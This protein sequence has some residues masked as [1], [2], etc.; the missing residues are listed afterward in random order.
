MK[1][2]ILPIICLATAVFATAA[3][4][5]VRLSEEWHLWKSEHGKSYEDEVEELERHSIWLSNKEYIEQHNTRSDVFGYT[6][7][8]NKFGDLSNKEF[9]ESSQCVQDVKPQNIT[10]L[11]AKYGN[12]FKEFTV[13]LQN[14]PDTMDW[15]TSGAVGKVKDQLRCGCSYAFA[16]MGALEGASALSRGSLNLLSEQNI[17]DCSGIYGNNGCVC[18]DINKSFL[19]VIDNEGVDLYSSYRYQSKQYACRY[20][21]DYRGATARG[22][23]T[24]Q[25]GD[26][27]RLQ[28]ALAS[29]GPVS[30]YIDATSTSFQF[31]SSGILSVPS[32]S[33]TALS[34]AM[35]MTGY[36]TNQ[37]Q[38]YWLL[39][40]SWGPNWGELGYLRIVRN[41][42]NQCGVATAASYPTL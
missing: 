25:S 42:A 17:V 4:S 26:E 16:A 39:K 1:V 27:R 29:V 40:N 3:A 41:M 23:V 30:T 28:I 18:G 22:V 7:K 2:P 36:G 33:S 31:Y 21:P 5:P 12:K 24:I 14:F 11:N 32:C 20:D 6:L 35:V 15:R 13:G 19:Y 37:G 10:Y 9:V 38:D 8:M 34:H